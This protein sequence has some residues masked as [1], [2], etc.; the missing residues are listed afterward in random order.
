MKSKS[1]LKFAAPKGFAAPE[2]NEPGKPFDVLATVKV[3]DD[4]MVHLQAIDGVALSDSES[5]VADPK[6]DMAPTEDPGF[7]GAVEKG[8]VA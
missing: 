5:P 2:D 6:D 1:E 8:M 4:G 3:G 7:L